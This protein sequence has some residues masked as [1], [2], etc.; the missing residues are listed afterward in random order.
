MYKHV[1]EGVFDMVACN[2]ERQRA[3]LPGRDMRADASATVSVGVDEA[4]Q[5]TTGERPGP[6]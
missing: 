4:R 2:R 3:S 6:E 5:G 1:G